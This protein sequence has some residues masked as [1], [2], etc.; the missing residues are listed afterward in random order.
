MLWITV[1]S[2]L[3][4]G[5]FSHSKYSHFNWNP[6]KGQFHRTVK[7]HN[8][9][10]IG[11]VISPHWPTQCFRIKN[12]HFSS[13]PSK[14]EFHVCEIFRNFILIM[15]IRHI[16][17]QKVSWFKSDFCVSY[18]SYITTLLTVDYGP[19]K[20]VYLRKCKYFFTITNIYCWSVKFCGEIHSFE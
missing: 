8:W 7:F 1:W 17:Q 3:P 11:H 9:V 20:V 4:F 14:G 12:D 16:D 13:N 10:Q 15:W 5:K 19:S 6:R 18:A 2:H